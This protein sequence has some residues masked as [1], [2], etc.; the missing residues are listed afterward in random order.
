MGASKRAVA[1]LLSVDWIGTLS[2]TFATLLHEMG[3]DLRSRGGR[4]NAEDRSDA[5]ARPSS[6]SFIRGSCV[7]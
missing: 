3:Y 1:S 2:A 7:S 5:E 4:I 6:S